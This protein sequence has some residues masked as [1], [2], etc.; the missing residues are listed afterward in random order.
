MVFRFPWVQVPLLLIFFPSHL[1]HYQ[2]SSAPLVSTASNRVRSPSAPNCIVIILPTWL[3]ASLLFLVAVHFPQISYSDRTWSFV[4]V[5]VKS[6]YIYQ[7]L[8]ESYNLVHF[9]MGHPHLTN[10]RAEASPVLPSTLCYCDKIL[11]TSNLRKTG[12]LW[13]IV[14]EV[15][16]E[17]QIVSTTLGLGQG[18]VSQQRHLA[19]GAAHFLVSG[20]QE[21]R[22]GLVS[23]TTF[24]SSPVT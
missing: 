12:W 5:L 17:S 1:I 4:C 13:L 18:G 7:K 24:R 9:T 2:T 11:Q 20:K 19:E 14:S 10:P 15:A 21:D 6:I 8:S 16:D 22:K 23:K 3:L